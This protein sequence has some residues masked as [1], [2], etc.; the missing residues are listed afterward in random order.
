MKLPRLTVRAKL[1]ASFSL[2]LTIPVLTLGL[3]SYQSAK[4]RLEEQL[5]MTAAE[6]VRLVDELLDRTL[7]AQSR[8]LKLI[9]AEVGR[10]QLTEEMR[11]LTRT[12]LQT[13]HKLH[14]D[15]GEVYIGEENGKMLM[16]TDAKLSAGFDPRKRPWYQDAMAQP[17]KTIITDP[18]IDDVTGNV[19]VGLAKALSDRSGVLAIDIQLTSL[20][21]TVKQAKIG[22][23]GYLSILDA[24]RKLLIHPTGTPGSDVKLPWVE[25]LYAQ[26]VGVFGF[27]DEGNDAKATFVTN[28]QT[29]WKLMGVMYRT[30][31]E[32]AASPIFSRTIL[33]IAITLA[34]G[35][36]IVF[37]ILRSLLRP[38]RQLTI[39]SEKMSQG[40]VTQQV[41]VRSQDELGVLGNS[42][43]HMAQSLRSLLYSVN[44]SVQ[45][46]AASAE[47]L[48][49]SAD[50]TSKAT[51]QI[52]TT[53]Q[54]MATGTEQQVSHTQKS[55]EAVGQMSQRINQI[56]N[57]TQE[58]SETARK[59]AA[60]A[61]EGNR[62]VQAA[63]Q[64]MTASSESI[65]TLAK[66]VDSL[67]G[68]SQEIGKIV[69]VITTIASQTNLLALNA[70]IEA[71]R[72]GESGRG[73]AV[74]ADEV[75]K[76]AEQSSASA[77]QISQLIAAIQQETDL[78]VEV[79]EKS[80][81]EV[82]EGIEKVY[83]AGHSFEQIQSAVEDV[84]LKIGQVSQ[85]SQDI[86]EQTQLV[87]ELINHISDVTMQASDGTQS[88]S[89][90]AEEQLAS[91]EE[92]ASSA[93]SLE[94]LAEGLQ[95][96]IG[97]FKI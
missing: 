74:V 55:T 31:A 26:A 96:Q 45:Q 27:S 40:D 57:Y 53:M 64:Q 86:S 62:S 13:F 70:A 82:T 5:L 73:F 71:A 19:I 24:N 42:F 7:E 69:D 22:S 93:M 77:E 37:S 61:A 28:G 65:L 76:L 17:D 84:A 54:D 94:R 49:A 43:N 79:M 50:Q 4:D 92:I 59:T 9:A 97:K 47:Q 15:I 85:A 34:V 38:L 52:A 30:E 68:R 83:E 72:A 21:E 67:G 25:D 51:E 6:N 90:A 80:K 32:T 91:M 87:V 66:V 60:V 35:A 78:A 33:V 12:K 58:V 75:R 29:G 18:Y 48:S 20:N 1:I 8:D 56:A 44:D 46:L 3:L 95:D 14:P 2:I 11:S 36:G 39:A 10:D 81:R 63:V 89:A 23:K 41:E 88:V 16:S